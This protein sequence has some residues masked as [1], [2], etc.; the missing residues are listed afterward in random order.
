MV[1]KIG[2]EVEVKSKGATAAFKD[3]QTGVSS[4]N[5]SLDK[6]R[7][8]IQAFDELT[9]GAVTQVR[10]LNSMFKGGVKAVKSLSTSFKGLRTAL[11]ATGI[12][13]FVV[14]LGLAVAYWEEISN[15]LDGTNLKLKAQEKRYENINKELDDQQTT[16]R[17]EITLLDIA[18]ESTKSKRDALRQSLRDQLSINE[19]K[20]KEI[21]IDLKSERLQNQELTL[22]EKLKLNAAGVLGLRFKAQMLA[23]GLNSESEKTIKLEKE[24]N[25]L[26]SDTQKT[27]V[28]IGNLDKQEAADKQRVIDLAEKAAQDKSKSL[29]EIEKAEA[30]TKAEIRELEEKELAAHYTNLIELANKYEQDTTALVEAKRF[31]EQELKAKY[32]EEDAQE[33]LK[34]QEKRLEELALKDET[35]LLE[36]DAQRELLAEQRQAI[37]DDELLSNEQK[38]EALKANSEA[39]TEITTKE[40]DTKRALTLSYAQSLA[41]FSDI[42]GKQTAAGKTLAV[43]STLFATY[44]GA[45]DALKDETL[46]G[47]FAKIAAVGTVLA[48]GFKQVKG[49]MSVQVPGGGSTPSPTMDSG[50]PGGPAFNVVGMGGSSQLASAIADQEAAP[51]RSYVVAQDVTTAQAL[52]R[53]IID[54]ASLG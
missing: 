20:I 1:E 5:K 50:V 46:P 22:F 41:Q 35:E 24:L 54:S 28:E 38:Q 30:V 26:L 14:G 11:I 9:G 33:L 2:I 40:Y 53:S 15:F 27:K 48:T 49:I 3:L 34:S 21:Q 51:S 12:G 36:F 45:S 10:N 44:Q 39:S 4:F 13:V 8:G 25:D 17:N 29:A 7:E 52:E 37:T 6:N 47:T 31:K 16:L 18:G 19:A 43:A 42:L 32:K 23:E